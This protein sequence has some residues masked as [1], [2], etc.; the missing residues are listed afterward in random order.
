MT[1]RNEGANTFN[2]DFYEIRSPGGTLNANGWN[3]LADQGVA[4][5][6]EGGQSDDMLLVEA[7]L[8]DSTVF[9][10]GA[11]RAIGNGYS[12]ATDARDLQ[13][14]YVTSSGIEIDGIVRYV[15][16][17]VLQGD[18]NKNG[19]VDAADYTVW[20][21]NFGAGETQPCAARSH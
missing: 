20:K 13:F 5:W 11:N 18:Y 7:N 15:Q 3:S 19:T 4:G 8:T 12:A 6:G 9:G 1:F 10:T 2:V 21:D 14:L 16:G 17:S